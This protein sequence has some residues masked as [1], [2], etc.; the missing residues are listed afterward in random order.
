MEIDD[1]CAVRLEIAIVRRHP[2]R[3]MTDDAGELRGRQA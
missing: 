3:G 1:R 2:E